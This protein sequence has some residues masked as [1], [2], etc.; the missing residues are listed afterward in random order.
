MDAAAIA[1]RA[2]EAGAHGDPRYLS[3]RRHRSASTS[4]RSDVDFAVGGCLKWLCGGPGNAFLYTRPELL[5]RLRPAFTGWLSH[6][7]PFAFDIDPIEIATCERCD[8]DD[9]RDAVDSGVLRGAGGARHH[10]RSGRA[11]ASARSRVELTGGCS[12]LSTSTAS[13]SAASRDPERLAGTVAINVPD[14]LQVARTLKAREFIVDYRPPVGIRALAAFLQHDGR[15]RSRDG[16]DRVDRREE[17]LRGRA[18]RNRW[19]P[20]GNRVIGYIG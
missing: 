9:E 19:S 7:N 2:R 6:R 12:R 5:K 18:R 13:P 14:A 20:S 8:G 11:S 15:S 10:P 1:R 3:V 16:G 17:G 4:P